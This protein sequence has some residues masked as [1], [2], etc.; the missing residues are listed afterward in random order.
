MTDEWT[1]ESKMKEKFWTQLS[2]S[3]F[4]MLEL[5]Q[6]PHSAVPMTAQLD[7][8]A[9]GAIW[10]FCSHAAALARLGPATAIFIAKDHKL[11]A[12]FSGHLTE[13]RSREIVDKHWTNAVS[14]WFPEG[15]NSPHI[16]LMRMDLAEASIWDAE[17]GA[18]TLTKM[19]LGVS[20]KDEVHGRHVETSL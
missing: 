8:D 20:V 18:L 3:P 17:L 7:K 19:M 2:K 4:V 6:V 11:F 10:F 1:A 16:L 15:R 13:E 14:A 12:R 5:D 9:H